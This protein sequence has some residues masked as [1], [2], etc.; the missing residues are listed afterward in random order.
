MK[1]REI[2]LYKLKFEKNLDQLTFYRCDFG[3]SWYVDFY[4]VYEPD[5]AFW[6]DYLEGLRTEL[7]E[8]KKQFLWDIRNSFEYNFAEKELKQKLKDSYNKY[9]SWLKGL[10]SGK[11]DKVINQEQ[12]IKL[13]SKIEL[14]KEL[15]NEKTLKN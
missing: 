9:N 10:N 2:E 14:L 12:R 6:Q 15:L 13:E 5:D 1:S 3:Q 11:L 4:S 7:V 8:A